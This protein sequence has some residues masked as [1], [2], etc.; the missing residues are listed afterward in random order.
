MKIFWQY[1]EIV[2]ADQPQKGSETECCQFHFN[3]D[4]LNFLLL[5]TMKVL[6]SLFMTE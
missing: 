2:R 5:C 3:T 1:N 6:L 4:S